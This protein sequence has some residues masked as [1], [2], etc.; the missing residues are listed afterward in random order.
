MNHLIKLKHTN[1]K[2]KLT[3]SALSTFS[4]A[5]RGD[6]TQTEPKLGNQYEEDVFLKESLKLDIPQ[7]VHNFH[8]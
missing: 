3:K 7:E 8:D 2:L 1:L 6:F 4:G 5:K